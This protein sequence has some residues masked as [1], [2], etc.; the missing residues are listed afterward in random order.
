MNPEIP[1]TKTSGT[2]ADMLDF[3]LKQEK[4]I[5]RQESDWMLSYDVML[6]ELQWKHLMR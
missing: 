2:C 5:C 6:R 1:V 4:E 3:I